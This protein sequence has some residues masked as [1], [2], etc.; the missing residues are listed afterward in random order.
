MLKQI[1]EGVERRADGVTVI[2]P[3]RC[4]VCDGEVKVPSPD[5]DLLTVT[6]WKK[7]RKPDDE[8]YIF[9][10]QFSYVHHICMER[11]EPKIQILTH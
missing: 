4:P 11:A 9:A 8:D 1:F 10:E 3:N 7:N 5:V 2:T 6:L